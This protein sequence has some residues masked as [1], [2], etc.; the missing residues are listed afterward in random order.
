[1]A[2]DTTSLGGSCQYQ[3]GITVAANGWLYDNYQTVNLCQ[4]NTQ[5]LICRATS[6]NTLFEPTPTGL[7]GTYLGTTPNLVFLVP[8]VN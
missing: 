2:K 4:V 7:L 3:Q 8:W 1:M 6:T 5:T